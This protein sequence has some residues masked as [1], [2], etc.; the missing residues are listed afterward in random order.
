MKRLRTCRSALVA[1]AALVLVLASA[2]APAHAGD[3]SGKLEL[4]ESKLGK[5]PKRNLGFVSRVANPLKKVKTFEPR[6][7]MVVVL[8][9]GEIPE[10]AKQPPKQ[11]LEYTLVGESFA[12][13]LFPIL[14][15]TEVDI[16]N[17][18][19]GA[20]TLYSPDA[21]DQIS[22]E[23]LNPSG[24]ENVE[25]TTADKVIR[26]VDKSS[27]HLEGRIVAFSSP[28]FAAVDSQG[29]YEIEDVP[30]GTW[31][32]RV[33]YKDGWLDREDEQIEVGRHS[34]KHNPAIPPAL[35][36]VE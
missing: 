34:T 15:G 18:G 30:E 19:I 27:P 29:H 20:P 23:V 7:Y 16:R 17:R 22:G 31:T 21:P 11:A 35:S 25:I 28:Y 10:E 12:R 6:P 3:V 4:D 8:V 24:I 5:P 33:W 14:I 13:P 2:T 9:G 36:I 26:I 32:V 1:S